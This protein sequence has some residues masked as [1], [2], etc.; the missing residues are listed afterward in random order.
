[1]NIGQP[2]LTLYEFGYIDALKGLPARDECRSQ[3]YADGYFDAIRDRGFGS[4]MPYRHGDAAL[5]AIEAGRHSS[6]AH[7]AG[8]KRR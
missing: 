2:K 3:P 8:E 1:V 6:Y 5:Y 7:A 4:V